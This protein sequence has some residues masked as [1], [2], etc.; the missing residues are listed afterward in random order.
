MKSANIWSLFRANFGR[1]HRVCVCVCLRT[2][3]KGLKGRSVFWLKISISGS[4]G[5]REGG[6]VMTRAEAQ[7][8]LPRFRESGNGQKDFGKKNTKKLGKKLPPAASDNDA[9]KTDLDL[10]SQEILERFRDSWF[11]NAVALTLINV[12][13]KQI[14]ILC[15]IPPKCVCVDIFFTRLLFF[16]NS[17]VGSVK[18]RRCEKQS[19]FRDYFLDSTICASFTWITSVQPSKY[20]F[21]TNIS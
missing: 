2:R 12:K 5:Q 9:K 8:I 20:E 6:M 16:L 1:G 17:Q 15:P 4:R 11:E 14:V 13:N 7:L 10:L 19:R 18:W 3:R 21:L